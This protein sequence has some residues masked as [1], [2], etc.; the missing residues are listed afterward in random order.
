MRFRQLGKTEIKVSEIS[1]GGWAIGGSWG[2]QNNTDSLEAL[3]TAVE[4]GVNFIDT[5]AGYGNG[6]SERIIGK[7]IKSKLN[8]KIYVATKIPPKPGPWPPSPYCKMEE[9]YPEEY[10]R[11]NIKERLT[12]LQTDCLDI[13]LLHTWTRAWNQDPK[14]LLILQE[15]KKEGLVKYVG[16]SSPEHDQNSIIRPMEEGLV[17][18]VEIIYN[19]FEQEPAAE[20]LPLAKREM[21]GIIVRVPFDEGSLTGKFNIN[22]VFNEGDFRSNYFSGDRLERTLKKVDAIK[23]DLLNQSLSLPEV[24]LKFCLQNEAVST[25]I[26]GMRNKEQAEKNT[27]VSDLPE[28]SNQLIERL[29]EHN[30]RKSFWY[31]G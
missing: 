5:A 6:H 23:Q 13:L 1:F 26:P 3:D 11:T 2:K 24:A 12:N 9:R 19:I 17:D 29:R 25:V 21:I 4:R 15:L 27:K 10:I 28:L 31:R 20:I 7:F 8:R 14:P 16:I 30:W 18:V 22:T